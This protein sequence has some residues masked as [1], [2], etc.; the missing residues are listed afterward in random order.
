M[1]GEGKMTYVNLNVNICAKMEHIV[2]GKER[3][4]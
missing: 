2:L 3:D 4:E 1:R